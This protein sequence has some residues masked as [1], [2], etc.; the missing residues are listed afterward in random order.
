MVR[1]VELELVVLTFS[2]Y[3]NTRRKVRDKN[4]QPIVTSVHELQTAGNLAAKIFL[5]SE[6]VR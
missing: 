6:F 3:V 1:G 2:S 5:S 4:Q